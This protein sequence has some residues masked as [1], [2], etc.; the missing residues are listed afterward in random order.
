MCNVSFSETR[1]LLGYFLI[2]SLPRSVKKFC[3]KMLFYADQ[4]FICDGDASKGV[5]VLHG[6]LRIRD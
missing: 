1:P 3:I 2:K 5:E 4:H 6:F